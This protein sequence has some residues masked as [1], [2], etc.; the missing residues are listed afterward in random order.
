MTRIAL[1]LSILLFS[2]SCSSKPDYSPNPKYRTTRFP[3]TRT[4][5]EAKLWLHWSS[6]ERLAFI[7]GFAVG[8]QQ[9]HSEVCPVAT[10]SP[11]DSRQQTSQA[12]CGEQSVKAQRLP[13]SVNA[14][15]FDN[16]LKEYSDSMTAFYESYEQDDDVPIMEL[17]QSIVFQRETPLQVHN[18]LPPR[19]R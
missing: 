9:A 8:Y 19:N 17:L 13:D 4:D 6:S 18:L 1:L 3:A 10:S 16:E 2:L 15:F 12:R 14:L 11:E 7:R 5:S